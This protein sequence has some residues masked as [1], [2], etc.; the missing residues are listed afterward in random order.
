[1]GGQFI[2]ATIVPVPA[3]RNRWVENVRTKVQDNQAADDNLE[4]NST[5]SE[6]WADSADPKLQ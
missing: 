4:P 2:D 1:M 3:E 5:A 6:V